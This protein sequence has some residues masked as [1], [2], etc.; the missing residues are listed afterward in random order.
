MKFTL[1]DVLKLTK[2]LIIEFILKTFNN[3][4]NNNNSCNMFII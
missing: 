4:N 3:Y 1:Y 2:V